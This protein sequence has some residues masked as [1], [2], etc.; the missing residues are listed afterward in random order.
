MVKGPVTDELYMHRCLQLASLGSGSVAPNPMVGAV[1]VHDERIIGEGYHRQYGEAHAEVNCIASVLPE[2]KGLIEHATLYVSL[3]PCAHFGKTPPCT[4]LILENKIP[5][6]VVACRDPFPA[7]NG[8]GIEKLMS[9]GVQVI[10]G[11][12]EK[13]AWEQN[14][15][16]FHF[17][18]AHRPYII[19]K[20]A[21]TLDQKIS[22]EGKKRLMISNEFTNRLVHKWRT[23][24]AAIFI[25]S[26][27]AL[28]DN[29][30]LTSRLWP[31]NDPVRLVLDNQLQLPPGLHVLDAEAPTVVFN[32]VRHNLPF[33][34]TEPR[35]LREK[36]TSYYQIAEDASMVHQVLN[37]LYRMNI[38]SVLVEGGARVLQSFID[39]GMWDEARVITG[40][41]CIA[42]KGLAAPVLTQARLAK[43][44]SVFTDHIAYYRP[45]HK[46]T[47]HSA[48]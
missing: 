22:G 36:G 48:S 33:E 40:R 14:R 35:F 23:E 24:E 38:L 21:Q 13:E 6:V 12:L 27:T 19:L 47:A 5:R 4:R 3:E 46:P 30:R 16:F 31:G 11:I 37:A 10:S 26:G 44:E 18:T 29:P 8:K 41:N 1:L 25:G 17:H 28:H 34:K 2:D 43:E 20:W 9:A 32:R 45:L 42:G 7:V 39:E 15:R